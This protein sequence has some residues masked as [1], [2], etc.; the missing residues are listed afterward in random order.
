MN[1]LAV[2][3]ERYQCLCSPIVSQGLK[4]TNLDLAT[5]VV[6]PGNLTTDGDGDANTDNNLLFILFITSIY[7]SS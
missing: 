4:G 2:S 3:I 5:L 6:Q 7:I 1:R